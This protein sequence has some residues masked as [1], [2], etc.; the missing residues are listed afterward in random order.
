MR[1]TLPYFPLIQWGWSQNVTAPLPNFATALTV[2]VRSVTEISLPPFLNVMDGGSGVNWSPSMSAFRWGIVV[3]CHAGRDPASRW[4]NDEK[5]KEIPASA[6]MTAGPK[7][8]RDSVRRRSLPVDRQPEDGLRMGSCC[9][10][11]NGGMACGASYFALENPVVCV[12]P[13]RRGRWDAGCL[14]IVFT[15]HPEAVL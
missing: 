6:G 5:L 13:L 1:S 14:Q 10:V 3:V 11:A 9:R 8:L 7:H 15:Y 4:A 12:L 2:I